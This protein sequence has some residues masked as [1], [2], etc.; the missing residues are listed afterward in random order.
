MIKKYLINRKTD[1]KD[2]FNESSYGGEG[3][4][5]SSESNS[6]VLESSK[7]NKK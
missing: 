2:D 6:K 7:K 1:Y 4:E 5:N 3:F